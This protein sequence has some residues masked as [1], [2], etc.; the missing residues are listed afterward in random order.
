MTNQLDV[1]PNA[2]HL[3]DPIELASYLDGYLDYALDIFEKSQEA[4]ELTGML[5]N[6]ALFFSATFTEKMPLIV[7]DEEDFG[8]N[9]GKRLR[10]SMYDDGLIETNSPVMLSRNPQDFIYF[11]A[12]RMVQD[13]VALIE[14]SSE[15]KE[16]ADVFDLRRTAFVADWVNRFLGKDKYAR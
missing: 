15:K 3:S 5:S 12:M 14:D 13:F 9:L 1:R 4:D 8:E 10:Q 11:A 2:A 6:H 16:S 7:I